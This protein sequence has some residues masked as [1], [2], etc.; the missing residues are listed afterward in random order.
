MSVV[1]LTCFVV[2]LVLGVYVMLH[3][4]ERDPA[5]QPTP[6]HEARGTHDPST[7]PSVL[8]NAQNAA[9]FIGSFGAGG[10]LLARF[11]A[12]GT[13]AL[14]ALA[15]LIGAAGV[16]LSAGVLAGWALPGA[17]R[18]TV[19][20]RYLLQGH[21]ARV[22]ASI[23]PDGAGEIEYEVDGRRYAVRARSWDGTPMTAGTDVAIERV[24]GGEAYVEHWAAVETRL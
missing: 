10:Y 14:V 8:F 11:T 3:G 1:F 20:E 19:D 21:P 6:P 15:V 9:A 2:G 18:E 24:E 23:P 17:R 13:P 4:V 22:T 12:L 7:E 5:T 16:A